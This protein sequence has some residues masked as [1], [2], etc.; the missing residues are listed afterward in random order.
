MHRLEA[1][2]NPEHYKACL[3][4][5]FDMI[6]EVNARARTQGLGT[7]DAMR[8]YDEKQPGTNCADTSMKEENAWTLLC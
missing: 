5:T 4:N 3:K 7:A 6:I 2:V 1:T 8:I